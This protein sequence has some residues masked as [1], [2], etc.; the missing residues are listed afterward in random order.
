MEIQSQPQ[1]GLG[2][3]TG[4]SV[5]IAIEAGAVPVCFSIPPV[6]Q[7]TSAATTATW[8]PGLIARARQISR[9]PDAN[10][11]RFNLYSAVSAGWRCEV[12]AAIVVALS[13]VRPG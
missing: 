10:D 3:L 9:S 7:K 1:A 11:S 6:T 13:H 2:I 8:R 5:S 12:A 4:T